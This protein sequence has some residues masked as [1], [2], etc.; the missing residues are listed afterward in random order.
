MLEASTATPKAQKSAVKSAAKPSEPSVAAAFTG[1]RD[2]MASAAR[3][4]SSVAN[5]AA[6]GLAPAS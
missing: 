6:S 5:G 2:P 1:G 3:M 4:S